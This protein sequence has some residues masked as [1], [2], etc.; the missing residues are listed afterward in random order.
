M[1]IRD[2]NPDEQLA[3]VALSEVTVISNRT[4][5]DTEVAELD[6]LVH[7]LGDELFHSLAEQ[8]ESRFADRETLKAFLRTISRPD[9][10]ELIYG[11]VL[12]EALADSMPHEEARFLEWLAGEWNIT[13]QVDTDNCD[14][15][16]ASKTSNR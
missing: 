15:S 10:R 12:T 2:L 4:V 16:V 8:A 13:V 1:T 11:T 3:L 14:N 6:N 9:A 5:T 7:E